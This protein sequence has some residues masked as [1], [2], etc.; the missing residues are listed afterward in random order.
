MGA[1]NRSSGFRRIAKLQRPAMVEVLPRL[2]QCHDGGFNCGGSVTQA[3]TMVA[4]ARSISTIFPAPSPA[5][6]SENG[7]L[8]RVSPIVWPLRGLEPYAAFRPGNAIMIVLP[9]V[10]VTAGK[11]YCSLRAHFGSLDNWRLYATPWPITAP[12][13]RLNPLLIDRGCAPISLPEYS[14]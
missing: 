12:L 8:P 3:S 11:V 1:R 14:G 10:R 7:D 9:A 2:N 5:Q 6:F 13:S 4:R